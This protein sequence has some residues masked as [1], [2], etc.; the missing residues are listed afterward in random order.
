MQAPAAGS[1]KLQVLSEDREVEVDTVRQIGGKTFFLRNSRW[2]DST[3]TDEQENQIRTIK[4]YSPEYFRLA[5]KY[6]QSAAKYLAMDGD[7]TV[8][9]GGQAY[10]L[11]D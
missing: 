6:G 8:V 2:V 9:L 10:A 3:M 11:R 1:V 7:I 5:S 4:R